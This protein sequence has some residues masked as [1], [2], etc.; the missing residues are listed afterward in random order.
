MREFSEILNSELEAVSVDLPEIQEID[1]EKVVEEKA[2]VAYKL[3]GKPT[4]VEDS[5][6]EFT[7]WN[8]LPG[9]LIKWFLFTVGVDGIL[10]ML[11][12]EQERE[13]VAKTAVA[14]FDGSKTHIFTGELKGVISKE[15]SG[16]N[17]FGWDFIFIPDGYEK[18]F[19]E[20]S[21]EEKNSIS[22]RKLALEKMIKEL[23][24]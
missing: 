6:L 23:Q 9:A 13:A 18:T 22:M 4:L 24:S 5:S 19:A 3:I 11:E 21:P 15:K 16:N 2:K 17:G 7:A 20:M 10:K 12:N 1:V 14:F 8:K